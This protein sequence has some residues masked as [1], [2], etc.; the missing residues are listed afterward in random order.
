LARKV[1]WGAVVVLAAAMQQGPSARRVAKLQ[2]LL[3]IGRRTLARWRGFWEE[4]F[5]A[6]RFWKAQ[7]AQFMPPCEET[8]MPKSLL[9]RFDP[10]G[11][12]EGALTKLLSFLSPITTRTG[13][14]AMGF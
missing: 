4:T 3:G 11:G 12:L 5:V 10:A 8:R 14:Q 7:R 13:V 2:E 1:Y 6:S 9:E